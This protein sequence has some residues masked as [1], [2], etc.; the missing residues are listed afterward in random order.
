MPNEEKKK[1]GVWLR[2]DYIS[3]NVKN[4]LLRAFSIFMPSPQ[5][6]L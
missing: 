2:V 1:V 5:Q 4:T 3:L 6:P